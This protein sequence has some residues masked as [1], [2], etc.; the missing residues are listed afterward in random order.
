MW[1]GSGPPHI[2]YWVTHRLDGGALSAGL[3]GARG[4]VVD[5]AQGLDGVFIAARRS[6]VA[7]LGFDQETFDGFHLYDLDFSYRAHLA[8]LRVAIA[9]DLLLIHDSA[10]KYSTEYWRYAERL[11]RKFPRLATEPAPPQEPI[12]HGALLQN[13]EQIR[14]LYGWI[15]RWARG[16]GKE[17][18]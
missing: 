9:L 13:V 5:A 3:C 2:H 11:C 16:Q 8:G 10:G 18:R 15:E 17:H 14:A 6:A 1:F 12:F 4:P 7:L